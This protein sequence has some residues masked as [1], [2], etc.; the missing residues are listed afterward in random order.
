MLSEFIPNCEVLIIFFSIQFGISLLL[1]F[2]LAVYFF[3][4]RLLGT[5]NASAVKK[6]FLVNEKAITE[7]QKGNAWLIIKYLI[8]CYYLVLSLSLLSSSLF[9]VLFEKDLAFTIS[10]ILLL[11]IYSFS[12]IW[13]V[14]LFYLE[15]AIKLN[16]AKLKIDD[17][18]KDSENE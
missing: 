18:K 7:L 10:S 12:L 8:L 15:V 2:V 11:F 16:D 6:I 1:L 9:F 3:S 14:V 13:L 4:D 17:Q 5:E